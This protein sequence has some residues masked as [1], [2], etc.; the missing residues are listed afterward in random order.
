MSKQQ[1]TE[2]M[3]KVIPQTASPQST[4]AASQPPA[5]NPLDQLRDIHLPDQIDQ[6]PYAPGWW[7]LL[8][9]FI[10]AICFMI[11]RHY[12]Y[13][14][15]IRLLIPAKQEI[16]ALKTVP[17]NQVSAVEIA[18]LSALLK[19]VCLIYFPRTSVASLNGVQWLAFLNKHF[20]ANEKSDK[21]ETTPG[22][23]FNQSGID[24][25]SKAA[26]QANPTINPD[27]WLPLLNS[28]EKCIES[29]IISA[30]KS[31]QKGSPTVYSQGE[32]L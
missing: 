26:Y 8:A 18:A 32:S 20:S 13:K 3:L 10:I 15:S 31:S 4:S 30:A 19:R 28:S 12:R 7:L 21:K 9:L 27:E 6:F 2:E 23:L 17:P 22:N 11:Y 14:K 29:I 24:L 1:P 16:L 25:F 5:E